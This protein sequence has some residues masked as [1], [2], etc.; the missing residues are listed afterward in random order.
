MVPTGQSGLPTGGRFP[1]MSPV[2]PDWLTQSGKCQETNKL[3]HSGF[4]IAFISR[5]PDWALQSVLPIADL[6]TVSPTLSTGQQ[7]TKTVSNLS[8]DKW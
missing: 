8:G 1:T 2:V 4:P 3:K 7:R 6:P 5:L